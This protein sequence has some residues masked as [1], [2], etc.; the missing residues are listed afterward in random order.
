MNI[1]NIERAFQTMKDR[2]WDTLWWMIDV[3]DTIFK[4]KY[5]TDQDFEFYSGCLEVL[6]WISDQPNQEII[7]WTSSFK[8]DAQRVIDYFKENHNIVI[9]YF[10]EN[11]ECPNTELADFATKP[12]FNILLDDKGG[13]EAET[14]W[15]L[16]KQELIRIE[17]WQLITQM[18]I[19]GSPSEVELDTE[20][21]LIIKFDDDEGGR[22]TG[23]TLRQ[24]RAREHLEEW[25]KLYIETAK[26]TSIEDREKICIHGEYKYK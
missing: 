26:K 9:N 25:N 19:I 2:N 10:N 4:G 11:P 12:Y 20:F 8:N 17:K 21:H 7:L 16:V 13:F 1:F 18:D 6:K 23:Y 3:H 22:L 14:D 24:L 15:F 5:A